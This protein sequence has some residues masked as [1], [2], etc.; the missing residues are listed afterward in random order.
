MRGGKRDFAIKQLSLLSY[1]MP[2]FYL[3]LIL[4]FIFGYKLGWFPIT[5]LESGKHTGIM[6]YLDMGYHLILPI[7]VVI[8]VGFGSLTL[9]IRSLTIDI[10]KSDYITFAIAKRS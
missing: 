3:A 9:Y 10:L 2:S 7:F 5:G 6:R 8:F 1:A 4:I